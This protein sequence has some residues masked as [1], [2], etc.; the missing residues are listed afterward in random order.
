MAHDY[1]FCRRD[2]QPPALPLVEAFDDYGYRII[3]LTSNIYPSQEQGL[4]PGSKSFI[5]RADH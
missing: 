5:R 3:G 1:E 2:Q 4:R